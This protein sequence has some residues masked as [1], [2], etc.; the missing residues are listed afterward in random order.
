[1]SFQAA[2]ATSATTTASEDRSTAFAA[3]E[4]GEQVPGGTLMVA[5]YAIVW[6]V[7]LLLVVRVFQRQS[8]VMKQIADLE[9]DLAKKGARPGE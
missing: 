5:S 6:L 9:D 3:K 8:S 7:V 4:G 1:M 2:P